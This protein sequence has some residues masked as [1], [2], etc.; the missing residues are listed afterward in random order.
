MRVDSLENLQWFRS[1]YLAYPP[2]AIYAALSRKS[3]AV[4]EPEKYAILAR[5]SSARRS[6]AWPGCLADGG[7]GELI[8]DN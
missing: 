5:S 8:I 1:F 3:N 4:R 2:A 6:G 7:C